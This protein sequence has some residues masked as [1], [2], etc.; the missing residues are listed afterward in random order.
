MYMYNC[1]KRVFLESW[2][3]TVDSDVGNKTKL[4]PRAYALLI[5]NLNKKT[6][7]RLVHCSTSSNVALMKVDKC[8]RKFGTQKHR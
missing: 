3:S 7:H 8:H 5:Q 2:D 1:H 4:L 6:A